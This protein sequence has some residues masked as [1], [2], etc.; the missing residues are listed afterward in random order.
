ML[1]IVIIS[2]PGIMSKTPQAAPALLK[3]SVV[4]AGFTCQTMDFNIRFY[5][6]VS[7]P[8]RLE[9][10]FAT[11]LNT[12]EHNRAWELVEGWTK[13][14]I[15][16]NPKFVGISVFTYQNRIAA[17]L[18]CE[19]IRRL[20]NI[21]IVLG[22]QG[23]SDG[24][25][26]G[27]LGF[28][29]QLY[30]ENLID[31][32]IR[33]EGEVS[34][35]ELLRNN[36]NYPGINSD[37]F[38]QIDNLDTIPFPDYDDYDLDLYDRKVLPITGSRGCV[39][40]CSFCDIHEHWKYR[41]RDGRKIADEILYL[42]NKHGINTF[43]FSDSLINGNLKEFEKFIKILADHNKTA[44]NPIAWTSQ[45]IV[46]SKSQLGDEY[47]KNIAQSGGR[48]LAIGVETGS[49]R[50]R[51]HMNKRFTNQDLD[52]TMDML[53]KFNI[54][55]E[56]LL[57]VGYPTETDQ[58]FQETLD[59]FTRYKKYISNIVNITIGS[60]LGILPGTPLFNSAEEENIVLDKYENNWIAL[61]NP[62]LT[63]SK[64]IQR[65]QTLKEHVLNLGYQISKDSSD[66]MMQILNNNKEMFD[67]R[68]MIKKMIQI[69]NAKN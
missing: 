62:E 64:R 32:W 66:H 12:E 10:Y 2:I 34:L 45:F 27:Q 9:S 65:R 58:D 15:A 36:T 44:V 53:S 7:D 5:H 39:R 33:S 31:F 4:A 59:M 50:V 8:S 20:S 61:D 56:F 67:K 26:Q 3:A 23:L 47:W 69:K 6:D 24:G 17:R 57:I 38:K 63:L 30:D 54:T 29:K 37:T 52:Y 41:Y 1:D 40:S 22:G 48:N 19:H 18:F 16:L 13:E 35:V 25:I 14:I 42:S 11:G 21:K 68:L 55:C 46:R 43:S 51:A 60:T 28:G 49:D